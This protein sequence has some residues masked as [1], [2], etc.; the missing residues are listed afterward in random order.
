MDEEKPINSL[1]PF[2]DHEQAA[3]N[4]DPSARLEQELSA[5]TLRLQE[6]LAKAD[7]I[8]YQYDRQSFYIRVF[9]DINRA[10][11]GVRDMETLLDQFLRMTLDSLGVE[12]GG[13]FLFN[14]GEKPSLVRYRLFGKETERFSPEEL[15]RFKTRLHEMAV[16]LGLLSPEARGLTPEQLSALKISPGSSR[17]AFCFT[18]SES[19]IGLVTLGKKLNDLA[20]TLE[21]EAFLK[22]L[23]SNLAILLERAKAIEKIQALHLDM[24]QKNIFLQKAMVDLNVSESR[25]KVLEKAKPQFGQAFKKE[26]ERSRRVSALDFF[27][28]IGLGLVLGVIFNL[29]NPNGVNPIPSHWFQ[30]SPP[31][32]DAGRV[33][34]RVESG[35]AVLVDARPEFLYKQGHIKG[36]VNLPLA[37]FDFIYLMK[38][39]HLDPEREL[40]VYGRNIS[41]HYDQEVALQLSARG[42]RRVEILS[43]GLKS[44]QERGFPIEP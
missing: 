24:A 19:Y 9:F 28:I 13:V 11:S 16:G 29:V 18:L 3:D 14:T 12:E 34:S 43:G 31:Q 20:Y 2:R 38:F 30:P 15:E 35:K 10:L 40:I 42:H 37:L 1:K 23:V 32:I 6:A 44:W 26:L 4:L 21:E 22:N 33:K 25:V 27:L 8:Q 41:R 36:A 7:R 17:M 39:S 5:A